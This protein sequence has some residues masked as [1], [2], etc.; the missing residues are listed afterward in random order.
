MGKWADNSVR[1]KHFVRQ[2]KKIILITFLLTSGLSYS[3]DTLNKF[4]GTYTSSSTD[5]KSRET[6]LTLII[7]ADFSFELKCD[8]QSCNGGMTDYGT[9]QADIKTLILNFQ[10][11]IYKSKPDKK[12]TFKSQGYPTEDKFILNEQQLCRLPNLSPGPGG[13]NCYAKQ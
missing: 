12:V 13:L 5:L 2:M 10:Y 11:R 4:I 6:L 8:G 3:Q 9:Y 1:Q 7:K